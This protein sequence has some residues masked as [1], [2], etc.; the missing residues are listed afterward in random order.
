M[1]TSKIRFLALLA[2]AI[3]GFTTAGFAVGGVVGDRRGERRAQ[4][5]VT[6]RDASH[7]RT[8]ARIVEVNPAATIRDFG[9]DF[10]EYV[11]A[12]AVRERVPV[13]VL[14]ALIEKESEFNPRAV[15]SSGEVGLTQVLPT[16]AAL[17]AAEMGVAFT[18][19]TPNRHRT[20]RNLGRYENLGSLGD[21]RYSVAIGARYLGD[22]VRRYGP[23]A[24]ALRGYNRGPDAARQHRP[25][26]RYAE[27]V[28]LATLAYL[29]PGG[30]R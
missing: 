15:G 3:T 21:A 23:T 27:G 16:T 2:L 19:P 26:D 1:T 11:H 10:V 5:S 4:A 13:E 25:F 6:S 29:V 30:A 20:D 12:V 28:A 7:R 24:E 9:G 14:L 18:P 17:V 22:M 8:L